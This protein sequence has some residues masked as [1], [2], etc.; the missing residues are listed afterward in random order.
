M[1]SRQPV[2]RR[3]LP[4]KTVGMNGHFEGKFFVRCI[5]RIPFCLWYGAFTAVAAAAGVGF[6]SCADYSCS[7]TWPPFPLPHTP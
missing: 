4:V 6:L 3:Y 1:I 2:V 7:L 5:V